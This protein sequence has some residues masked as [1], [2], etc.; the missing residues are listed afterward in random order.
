MA[1]TVLVISDLHLA[2]GN[3]VLENWGAAQQATFEAMLAATQ[4]GGELASATV[5]LVINGDCFD[6]LLAKPHLGLR[7]QVDITVAHAKWAGIAAAHLPWFAAL[8][9][10]VREPGR[11]VTFII[12]N[13]DLELCFPSIRARVR[14]AI[15]GPP[16]TVRFC[17]TRAYLPWPDVTIDHGCQFDP[18]NVIPRLWDDAPRVSTPNQLE[19]HDTQGVAVGPATLPW[20]SR[21]FYRVFLPTKER[22][23][24]LDAM[25]PSLSFM[26]Q[27]ALLCLLAPEQVIA[28]TAALQSLMRAPSPALQ[29]I[30]AGEE[31][32]PTTLFW[33]LIMATH[34]IVQEIFGDAASDDQSAVREAEELLAALH[35]ADRDAALK[36]L[37]A[38]AEASAVNT[39]G[40]TL[41]GGLQALRDDPQT[42]LLIVGHTHEEGRWSLPTGQALLNC[43]SWFPRL[44]APHADEW[45]PS[46]AYWVEYPDAP[47]PGRDGARFTI[48]WLRHE[49]GAA[50]VGELIAWHDDTFMP[51]ADDAQDHW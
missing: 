39:G 9:A 18:W 17:L 1:A 8:R 51:V 22:F 49:P 36:A 20:G 48:A 21:Y 6:F 16:G 3:P 38:P 15:G 31:R 11:R 12:G 29:A 35:L 4:P 5:E 33:G 32:Q 25:I 26:R 19:T 50:T 30:A 13:H 27:S 37:F 44:A 28:G 24:Y 42:R 40:V 7:N 2:D 23:P 45:S 46:L 14:S 41:A 34:Q 10:F 47:Y 43:G